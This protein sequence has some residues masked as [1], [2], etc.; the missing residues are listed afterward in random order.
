[1]RHDTER[2]EQLPLATRRLS[3]LGQA[4]WMRATFP[5]AEGSRRRPQE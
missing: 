4:G 1:M 3:G 2:N 5:A